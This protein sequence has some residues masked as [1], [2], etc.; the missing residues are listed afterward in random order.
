MQVSEN[1]KT[2]VMQGVDPTQQELF[3][4]ILETMTLHA[5][6]LA[7]AMGGRNTHEN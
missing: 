3:F 1:W 2:L 7:Y 5:K 4:S 6:E